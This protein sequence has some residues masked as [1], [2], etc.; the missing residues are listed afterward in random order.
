M[1]AGLISDNVNREWRA[2]RKETSSR[3][4]FDGEA[5]A[6]IALVGVRARESVC[7]KDESA[8]G[9]AGAGVLRIIEGEGGRDGEKGG[10]DGAPL[11]WEGPGLWVV[12]FFFLALN[13]L[14]NDHSD[15]N[16]TLSSSA[17]SGAFSNKAASS[18]WSILRSAK[19]IIKTSRIE[20]REIT[21][22]SH[23]SPKTELTTCSRSSNDPNIS[24]AS[25]MELSHCIRWSQTV[26]LYNQKIRQVTSSGWL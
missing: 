6:K 10:E 25:L 5:S 12:P 23:Y 16:C 11:L 13:G 7:R 2:V 3:K 9:V 20:Q 22:H 19:R 15:S 24:Q 4:P 8:F 18:S 1:N 26:T 17:E 21:H 14:K